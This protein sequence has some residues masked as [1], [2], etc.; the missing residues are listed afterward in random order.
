[1]SEISCTDDLLFLRTLFK[2]SLEAVEN[3]LRANGLTQDDLKI[4]K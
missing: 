3:E 1:M 4:S 2:K